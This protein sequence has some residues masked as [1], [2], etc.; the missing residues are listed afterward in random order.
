M[1]APLAAPA[2]PTEVRPGFP[3]P[4]TGD[5]LPVPY[6][7]GHDQHGVPQ[8]GKVSPDRVEACGKA[9]MVDES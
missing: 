2:A 5:G 1:T 7:A 8:L 4:R 9:A 6:I 3:L